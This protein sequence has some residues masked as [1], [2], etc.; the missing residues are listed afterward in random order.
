VLLHEIGHYLGAVHSPEQDSVMRPVLGDRQSRRVDFRVKFDPLNMLAINLLAEQVRARDVR[1]LRQ[2]SIGTKIVLRD[3]YTQLAKALEKDPAAPRYVQLIEMASVSPL[4]RG[5]RS[6]VRSIVVAAAANHKLPD[7][8]VPGELL[9]RIKGDRLTELYFRQAADTAGR[10][11]PEMAGSAMLLGLGIALD[12]GTSLRGVPQSGGVS[13]L[14]ESDNERKERLSVLGRPTMH[15]REDLVQH[16]V[17]SASMSVS[18]GSDV[19]RSAGIVKEMLDA[20]GKSGFSFADLAADMAGVYFAERLRGGELSP[21]D[22]AQ[23]FTV[24]D[25]VP[26]PAPWP[27]NLTAAQFAEQYGSVADRRFAG[28]ITAIRRHVRSL[29]GY[30]AGTVDEPPIPSGNLRPSSQ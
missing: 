8:P 4:T 15:G 6:V 19:A 9:Q 18:L 3:L 29:P 25:F 12:R 11:P 21:K 1:E 23:A 20:R 10:L 16:F 24:K 27:E 5:T 30:R 28:Q 7:R 26:A 22:L 2:V 13:L 14:V 17:L